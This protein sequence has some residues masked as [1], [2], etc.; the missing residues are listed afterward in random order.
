MWTSLVVAVPLL[1]GAGCGGVDQPA[2]PG[3]ADETVSRAPI[4]PDAAGKA[5]VLIG[6]K[7]QPGPAEEALVRGHG[8]Q[9]KDVYHLVPAMAATIP[10]AAVAA[11]ERNPKVAYVEGDGE[12]YALA[13]TLPWGVD[14][15]DAELVH[16][17]TKGSGINVAVID[18]GI[19]TTHP[20]LDGNYAG[21]Y[22]F[23]NKD[24]DPQ[25][26]NGHGTHCAGI[27]A[28]EDNDI[29]VIGVAP[30]ASLY[31]LKVL[32]ARG[33]GSYSD[34]I[35][36][37]QWAVDHSM[38]IA[39]M[40]LGG[41]FYS[42]ALET[43]CKNA[44]EA[45]VLLVAAAGNSGNR[46]GKGDNVTYPARFD[47]VI[48]VAAT[49]TRNRRASWSSTGP[50]VELAAPGVNIYSTLLNGRY[51]TMSG[52]SMACPHVSG[53]AALVMAAHPGLPAD[54]VRQQLDGTA[55]DLGVSGRD[56]WYGYGLVN[57]FRA[58]Q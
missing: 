50:A 52:T 41:S 55:M 23:V 3:P 38:R 22:D 16:P 24:S 54:G 33:G 36:A 37:I 15:I 25:D 6:F 19:D 34:V 28:A 49:D 10:Q 14:R 35:A 29:G 30:E 47:S 44:Y 46:S 45:G 9:V 40:S 43:A 12:C 5:K 1:L 26:D 13:E 42:E 18:T 58:V 8:G 21:G 48:A 4:V 7:Q 17:T 2:N 53:A 11:L 27:I 20:D 32:D 51:G 31:A 56:P 57:A 39:S